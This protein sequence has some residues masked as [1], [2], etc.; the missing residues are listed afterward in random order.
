ML[1]VALYYACHKP[2]RIGKVVGSVAAA[3][4][5]VSGITPPEA[6]LSGAPSGLRVISGV[7]N[8]TPCVRVIDSTRQNAS[9]AL[10]IS[11]PTY[12]EC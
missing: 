5:L 8:L 7:Q 3:R 4:G 1:A 6:V 9:N 10:R 12:E 11:V 2:A